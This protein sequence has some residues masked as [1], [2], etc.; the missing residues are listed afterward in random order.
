LPDSKLAFS[1]AEATSVP[2]THQF[3]SDTA[4]YEVLLKQK[5]S[6][7]EALKA[8]LEQLASSTR[9]VIATGQRRSCTRQC[10]NGWGNKFC[11]QIARKND[12]ISVA[13][14]YSIIP[15]CRIIGHRVKLRCSEK[16]HPQRKVSQRCGCTS[17][18]VSGEIGARE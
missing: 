17:N 5:V 7:A 18:S 13:A 15:E 9:A 1:I 14:D 2:C 8:K 11:N 16:P 4:D 3:L 10:Q 12:F 6:L